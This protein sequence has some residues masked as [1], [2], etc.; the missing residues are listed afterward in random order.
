MLGAVEIHSDAMTGKIGDFNL[1][2]GQG[3]VDDHLAA[4]RDEANETHNENL[5]LGSGGGNLNE[6]KSGFVNY[7]SES[8][9]GK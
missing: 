1:L 8:P 2:V 6:G 9:T 5:S 4:G 3:I 7:R